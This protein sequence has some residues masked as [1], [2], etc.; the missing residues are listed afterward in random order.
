M[1]IRSTSG[2]RP[3]K[4]S[5]RKSGKTA[6]SA[7]KTISG[8]SNTSQI[9]LKPDTYES[10]GSLKITDPKDLVRD[11]IDWKSLERFFTQDAAVTLENADALEG[12]LDH[13]AS[14]YIAAKKTLE[15]KY[16]DQ[17]DKYTEGMQ[18]L[19]ALFARGKNLMVNSFKNTVGRFYEN[20]GNKGAGSAM[21]ESL[22]ASIDEKID[23]LEAYGEKNGFFDKEKDYDFSTLQVV[24][25]AN[26][27]SKRTTGSYPGE[28]KTDSPVSPDENREGYSL[29]ELAAAGF[30]AK[31]AS[32]MNAEELLFLDN[33]ELAL[34]LALR[35]MKMSAFLE[36]SGLDKEMSAFLLGTFETC[37][38]QYSGGALDSQN[39]I[40][41]IYQYAMKQYQSS[42]DISESLTR[43][44][45]HY[46]GDRYFSEFLLYNNQTSLSRSTRYNLDI[47]QFVSA[48]ESGNSADIIQ[49]ISGNRIYPRVFRA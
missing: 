33:E 12:S 46:M 2:F 14:L 40:S 17:K 10:S 30:V 37:L 38:N 13:M 29:K 41:D 5:E 28:E 42:K 35:Q 49:S 15:N 22:S 24:L 1:E 32:G 20:M 27:L 16:S 11:T 25:M 23:E 7:S 39:T 45:A 19:D 34:Q 44:A 31:A 26:C 47:H 48:L 36:H 4:A 43:S 9:T 18:R 21:G 6:F 8:Q 3:D